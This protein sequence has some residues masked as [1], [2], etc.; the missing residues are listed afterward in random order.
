VPEVHNKTNL[1][2]LNRADMQAFFTGMGEKAFR[3]D[4]V[5]QWIHRYAVYDF[6]DMTNLSKSLRSKLAEVAEVRLPEVVVDQTSGD[7]TRKWLLQLE[8]G[9]CIETVFIPESNRGTLCVSSQIGCALDCRFCSTGKQGFN[10]NLTTAEIISQLHVADHAL[11]KTPGGDR[12]I[13]NVVLMGMGEPLLNFDNVVRA[14]DIMMDDYAY[15]L[16]KR[17]VTLSTAGVVPALDRLRE[18]SDVSLAVSLHAPDDALRDELVPLNRKYPIKELMAACRRFIEGKNRF[19]ITWEY[20]M[21]D[22]INDSDAHAR[23]LVK[24][25][26][27]IPSKVNL[28]PFNPFPQSQYRRSPQQ[29]IDRFRDILVQNGLVTITRRT[30]GDD[31]DAACGQLAGRVNDKTKRTQRHQVAGTRG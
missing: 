2:G 20:V 28:I 9:N 16:S 30:R 21:L 12:V 13:T 26:R 5:M 17:R 31:I 4:Q 24:L 25:L 11:G 22:G 10:R 6:A 8:S 3:A 23:A 1:L 7:G 19:H 14:I 15:G 29:R 27:G 18:T